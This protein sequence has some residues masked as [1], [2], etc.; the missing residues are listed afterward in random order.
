MRDLLRRGIVDSLPAGLTLIVPLDILPRYCGLYL[1]AAQGRL[2]CEKAPE[3]PR[4]NV[5]RPVVTGCRSI[6]TSGGWVGGVKWSVC[7]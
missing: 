5:A 2:I 1:N 7:W 3:S 4:D 6:Q